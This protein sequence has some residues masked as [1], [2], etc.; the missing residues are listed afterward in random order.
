MG[1]IANVIKESSDVEH[2]LDTYSARNNRNW[3]MF[4]EAVA[5]IKNFAKAAFLLE[6]LKKNARLDR[7]FMES[8]EPFS[9]QAD[10]AGELFGAAIVGGFEKAR[11]ERKRLGL[12][13]PSHPIPPLSKIKMPGEIILPHTIEDL[14]ST[15]VRHSVKKIA[16][17]FLEVAG[18]V[19]WVRPIVGLE[20][21]ELSGYIPSK[22][23][24]RGIRK[25]GA[26]IHNLQSWY[27]TYVFGNRFEAEY[28]VLKIFRG[29]LSAQVNLLKIATILSHY[30]ERH[31]FMVSPVSMEL[32]KII[33]SRELLRATFHFTLSCSLTLFDAGG[34]IA[35]SLLDELVE[36][37]TY[38]L[39]VPKDLGFH[40]RPST[41]VA[42]VVKHYGADVKMLV[43]D[44]VFDA[45]SILWLLSAGG[46][47]MTKGLDRVSFRGDKRALDD[48]KLL[49]D[50]NYGETRD[51]KDSPLPESLAYLA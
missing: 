6:E 48:L 35:G 42:K 10:W 38:E 31:L 24:E 4:R 37:V 33:P 36:I 12:N 11:Q 9:N 7:L 46:Y 45:G 5:T 47:I 20:A 19:Q 14:E 49:A 25:V 8:T 26:N 3:I 40:A 23:S 41:R 1:F 15:D 44:Q 27:D 30:Y 50:F 13:L 2:F 17:R 51:G 28:P 29:I 22:I 32:E 21:D 18:K 34:R 16:N 39:P 43:D